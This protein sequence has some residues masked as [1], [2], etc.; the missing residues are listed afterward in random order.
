[1]SFRLA[2]K[3]ATLNSVTA[4]IF[5]YFTEFVYDVV[6]KQRGLP[7]VSKSTFDSLRPY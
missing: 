3:S 2:Q 7:S 6:V 4:L 1:M 5:R